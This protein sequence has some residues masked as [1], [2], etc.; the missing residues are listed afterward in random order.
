M[1]RK[2][3]PSLLQ[4]FH[5]FVPSNCYITHIL[6]FCNNKSGITAYFTL[7]KLIQSVLMALLAHYLNLFCSHYMGNHGMLNLS[8]YLGCD[9]PI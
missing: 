3:A 2:F 7:R 5:N 1:G 4:R 6:Y 8:N 9:T